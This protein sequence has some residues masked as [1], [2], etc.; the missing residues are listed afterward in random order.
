VLQQNFG[1]KMQKNKRMRW[2]LLSCDEFTRQV[3]KLSPIILQGASPLEVYLKQV[4]RLPKSTNIANIPS[5]ISRLGVEVNSRR[6]VRMST[7][8]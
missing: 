4:M 3:H 6:T 7:S 5:M 8:K 1:D 2:N